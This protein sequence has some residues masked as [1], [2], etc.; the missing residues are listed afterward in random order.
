MTDRTTQ[1][2]RDKVAPEQAMGRPSRRSDVFA[3]GLVLWQMFSGHLPEWPFDLPLAGYAKLKYALHP[4]MIAVLK[5]ALERPAA[6][7]LAARFMPVEVNYPS[8]GRW[9]ARI[10]SLPGYERTFPPHWRAA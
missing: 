8:L 3:T 2:T 10:E 6:R 4:D 5:R 7:E 1:S 9:I